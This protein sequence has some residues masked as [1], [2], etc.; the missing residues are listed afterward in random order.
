MIC[1]KKNISALLPK[2]ALPQVKSSFTKRYL[3]NA[4]FAIRAD[5][6]HGLMSLRYPIALNLFPSPTPEASTKKYISMTQDKPRLLFD[7][8]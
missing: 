3:I 2:Q 5:G 4:M 7:V 8:L 6:H 1:I